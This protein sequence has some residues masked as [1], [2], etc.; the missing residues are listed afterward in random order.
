MG[1]CLSDAELRWIWKSSHVLRRNSVCKGLSFF[2]IHFFHILFEHQLLHFIHV[3]ADFRRCLKLLLNG[4]LCDHRNLGL[5]QRLQIPFLN[6]LLPFILEL[7]QLLQTFLL[8]LLSFRFFD[9]I[10]ESL[11]FMHHM[12]HLLD[13]FSTI[14]TYLGFWSTNLKMVIQLV[15]SYWF[16]TKFALLRFILTSS[17]VLTKNTFHSW[18]FAKA[19][20]DLG[21]FCLLMVVFVGLGHTLT[22]GCAFVVLTGASHFMHSESGHID[23]LVTNPTQFGFLWLSLHN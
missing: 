18:K 14:F 13:I 3:F 11:W 4:G 8:L 2:G 6:L 16:L 7:F 23:L 20:L 12:L 1:I 19:T 5:R 9:C 10:T 15:Y 21:V 17:F 22:A